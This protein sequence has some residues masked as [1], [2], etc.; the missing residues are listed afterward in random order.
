MLA[1]VGNVIG[2]VRS[3]HEG[4][5]EQINRDF[6]QHDTRFHELILS[7]GGNRR[8]V[9]VVGTW[10]DVTTVIGGWKLAE[11][12]QLGRSLASMSA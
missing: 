7:V 4:T 8:L 2:G 11:L 5:M 12:D 10:R 6:V 3:R 1:D 9:E